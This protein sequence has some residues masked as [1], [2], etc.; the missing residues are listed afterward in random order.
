MNPLAVLHACSAE[1]ARELRGETV[2]RR[3]TRQRSSLVHVLCFLDR[4]SRFNREW[5]YMCE[6][7]SIMALRRRAQP[8]LGGSL[9]EEEA[10]AEEADRG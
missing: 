9:A 7:A 5:V 1:S 8:G 6:E 4:F 3:E 2:S 10:A